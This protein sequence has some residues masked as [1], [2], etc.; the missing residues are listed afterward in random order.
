[1][2]E[3]ESVV[4]EMPILKLGSKAANAVQSDTED[5]L[6]AGLRKVPEGA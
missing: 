1:M 2:E 5:D 6:A 4:S 3:I